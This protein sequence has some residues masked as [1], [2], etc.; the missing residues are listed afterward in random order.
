MVVRG[1]GGGG[2]QQE[3]EAGLIVGSR[4]TGQTYTTISKAGSFLCSPLLV[5]SSG[6]TGIR[7][8]REI[9][10]S[11]F[12]DNVGHKLVPPRTSDDRDLGARDE[13]LPTSL[14]AFLIISLPCP[15][16]ISR[17]INCFP[18]PIST[19]RQTFLSLSPP[20]GPLLCGQ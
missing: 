7:S 10:G 15:Q 12:R 18:P 4:F 17:C 3:A 20:P 14:I 13:K 19:F 9:G 5:V 11:R 1:G 16:N 8:D 6:P 2:K